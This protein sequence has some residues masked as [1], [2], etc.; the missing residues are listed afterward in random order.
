M[1]NKISD[2]VWAEEFLSKSHTEKI[3][4]LDPI[5][6]QLVVRQIQMA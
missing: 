3:A 5:N 4:I 1:F 2:V 6:F